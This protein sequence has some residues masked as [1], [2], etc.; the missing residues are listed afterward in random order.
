MGMM[1]IIFSIP[2][3]SLAFVTWAVASRRLS[4]GLQHTTMVATIFLESGFWAL[5]R[6]EGMDGEIHFDLAWRWSKTA[7]ERFLAKTNENIITIKVDSASLAKEAEWP[8][9]RGPNHHR[10]KC[11]VI[12]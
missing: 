10:L 8:G 6:S 5:L 1:F 3:L 4:K 12:L 9:F 11:G 2:V 7:E